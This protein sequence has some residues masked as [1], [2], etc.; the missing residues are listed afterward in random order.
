MFRDS[1][2]SVEI[3]V[4]KL[5]DPRS[6]RDAYRYQRRRECTQTVGTLLAEPVK[7]IARR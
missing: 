3:R 7:R 1:H 4:R 5:I 6:P 2:T